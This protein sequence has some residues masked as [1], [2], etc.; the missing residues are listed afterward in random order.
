MLGG[1]SECSSVVPRSVGRACFLMQTCTSLPAEQPA[2][3]EI[4]AMAAIMS[5]LCGLPSGTLDSWF[6][7]G[8]ISCRDAIYSSKGLFMLWSSGGI[9]SLHAAQRLVLCERKHL[10]FIDTTVLMLFN[11]TLFPKVQKENQKRVLGCKSRRHTGTFLDFFF[12]FF[13]LMEAKLYPFPAA[14][15]DS[16]SFAPLSHST[17]VQHCSALIRAVWKLWKGKKKFKGLL[18]LEH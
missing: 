4:A 12:F 7:T 3:M 13:C 9:L 1:Y 5:V 10:L 16:V 11:E 2:L 18:F 14:V 6:H 17:R 8:L 15:S